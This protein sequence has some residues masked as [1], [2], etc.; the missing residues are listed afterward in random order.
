MTDQIADLLVRIRNSVAVG[1]YKILIPSSKMKRV[2]LAILKD[3]GFVDEIKAVTDKN[4]DALE[5]S[6]SETNAP[7][8][9]RQL[10]KPGRRLYSKSKEIPRPLRGMGLVIVS[11]PEG[12]ITGKEAIKRGIGG[13]LICE[14]W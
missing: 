4:H 11:T 9:L 12:V 1:K 2:I 8:H 6:V 5:V 14:I 13:E 3:E 7:R 10:S